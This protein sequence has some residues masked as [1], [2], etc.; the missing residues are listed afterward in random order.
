[1]LKALE[2]FSTATYFPDRDYLQLLSTCYQRSFLSDEE[3]RF[4]GYLLQKH[5]VNWLEW[6]Y[7]TRWLKN[8][9]RSMQGPKRMIEP[10]IQDNLSPFDQ[11]AKEIY[12]KIPTHLLKQPTSLARYA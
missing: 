11:A 2:N 1:M 6:S 8:T 10:L 3:A 12:G 9:I 7:K 5:Q 4:L